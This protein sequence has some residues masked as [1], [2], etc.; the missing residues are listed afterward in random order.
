M[1]FSSVC[2]GVPHHTDTVV[3]VYYYMC[4]PFL[5]SGTGITLL[6]CIAAIISKYFLYIL[7]G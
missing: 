7:P 5:L 4:T 6:Q 1:W 3:H 2:T